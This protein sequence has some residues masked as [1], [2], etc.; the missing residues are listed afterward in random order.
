MEWKIHKEFNPFNSAKLFAH[1]GYW[2]TIARGYVPPP[3]LVT[4]DP[5]TVCNLDCVWCN[6][7]SIIGNKQNVNRYMSASE[8]IQLVDFLAKWGVK[9]V[10]VAGGGEPLL[11][12]NIDDLIYS[13]VQSGIKVGV[14]TNGNAIEH[15]IPALSLCDWVSVSIDAGNGITYAKL[16]GKDKL[17]RTLVGM[18]K[19]IKE[20]KKN[21][22]RLADPGQGHG[23]TYKFL[24]HPE[25]VGEVYQ[26]A[27]WAK[28]IGCRNLHIRP[29]GVPHHEL[30]NEKQI[31][32]TE[33]HIQTYEK[34]LEK[35][36]VLDDEEF[37]VFAVNHKFGRGFKIENTFKKCWAVFMTAVFEPAR[38]E[39]AMFSMG[40]CCD[41]RGDEKLIVKD[42]IDPESVTK[43]WGSK[44]HY[45][46]HR[47]ILLSECP[48]CTYRPHNLIFEKV[49]LTENMT[50]DFI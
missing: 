27:L 44:G 2:K 11:N 8:M 10:C 49:I 39:G 5:C 24:L 25:N 7:K 12:A 21:K 3:L 19:L 26:A 48:R 34:Y 22:T 33:E 13:L 1:V 46:L 50:P 40:L 14:V 16:K 32:F 28:Q 36:F 41:R 30:K 37:S 23:V 9:A 35:S 4:I 47:S 45:E 31:G 42:A 17:V 20:S 18:E 15:H 43:F 38:H 6:S 29:V